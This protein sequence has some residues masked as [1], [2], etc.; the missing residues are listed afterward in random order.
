MLT[1]LFCLS[2]LAYYLLVLRNRSAPVNVLALSIWIAFFS[3]GC[4][5]FVL[6]VANN[7]PSTLKP[8]YL[9]VLFL[10]LCVIIGISGFLDF[11][12]GD[13]YQVITDIRGQKQIELAL[14]CLQAFAIIFFL[15]FAI[16][17]LQGDAN[18]NRLYVLEKEKLLGS[19]GLI[20]TFA[21]MASWLFPI[22][23]V[24][25]FIRFSQFK[26]RN[27][28]VFPAILLILTSLSFVIYV[29][30][31]V[32]RDGVIYWIMTAAV[33]FLLF[34]RHLH[35]KHMQR[36][37]LGGLMV[38]PFIM[39][40]LVII[41]VARF[42]GS[43]GGVAISILNYFGSQI[44]T[45]S[46]YSSIDRPMTY[47]VMNFPIFMEVAC[48]IFISEC[49]NWG[50]IKKDVFDEYLLQ[51]KDPWLFGTYVSDFVGDFGYLGTLVALS[52]FSFVCRRACTGRDSNGRLSIERLL[53]ILFFFLVPYWG[54][55]YFRL[56]IANSAIIANF[57]FIIFVW[58]VQRSYSPK[59]KRRLP[60]RPTSERYM[61]RR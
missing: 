4:A 14:I 16:S 42:A 22:S 60:S 31:Y 20:N 7:D 50:D 30:A 52:A 37:L 45:F 10:S 54:V 58:L 48:P 21:S 5:G 2:L 19:Y 26:E 46:D 11:R 6:T 39:V 35:Q 17:S 28:S 9:S 53:L 57:A 40:P 1:G 34:R 24:M 36:V 25:A 44:Q 55:F 61:P 18:T 59:P 33:I 41:T 8:N 51:G 43:D 15:P 23:L 49:A 13:V 38:A 12:S 32:G 47:G 27:V 29:L 3:L 56:G